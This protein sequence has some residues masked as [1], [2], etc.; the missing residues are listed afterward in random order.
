MK[1]E[2]IIYEKANN[3]ARITLN[4]PEVLNAINRQMESVELPQAVFDASRDEDVRVLI[5]TGAGRGFCAGGDHKFLMEVREQRSTGGVEAR[6]GIH[7]VILELRRMG[8]PTIAMVNGP[9]AGAGFGLAL[10]CDMRIGSENAR[11]RVAFTIIGLTPVDGSVWMLP[12]IVGISNACRIIFTGDVVGAEEAHRIGILDKLVP[13]EKLEAETMAL[14]RRLAQG[15]P[16]A[17]GYDK[18]MIYK[19]LDIDLET[20]LSYTGLSERVS[21][22][23][24]DFMEGIKAFAEKRQPVFRGK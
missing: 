23:S 3:I 6:G 4:R 11:F 2:T 9:A 22:A 8:K 15:P 18:M 24:E 7:D 14:A 16:I 21:M 5:I 13:A 10:A 1:Y 19:G 12:R 17:I 20:H